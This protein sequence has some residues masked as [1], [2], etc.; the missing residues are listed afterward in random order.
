[1]GKVVIQAICIKE[2]KEKEPLSI[3][4]HS[5]I[6]MHYFDGVVDYQKLKGRCPDWDDLAKGSTTIK[7]EVLKNG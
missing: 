5:T 7:Y 6:A 2:Y 3:V 1:M 4:F